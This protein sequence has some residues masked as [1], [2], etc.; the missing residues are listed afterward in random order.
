M[1]IEE[2]EHRLI[3]AEKEIENLVK[4]TSSQALELTTITTKLDNILT[5]LGELKQGLTQQQK[6]PAERWEKFVFTIIGALGSALVGLIL[7]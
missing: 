1:T 7:K 6:R 2:I 4:K 3:K 5:T